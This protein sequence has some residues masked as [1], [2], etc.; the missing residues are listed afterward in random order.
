METRHLTLARGDQRVTHIAVRKGWVVSALCSLSDES[1]W[2]VGAT[3]VKDCGSQ[4]FIKLA[5]S[6]DPSVPVSTHVSGV[7]ISPDGVVGIA[8]SNDGIHQYLLN[9]PIEQFASGRKLTLEPVRHTGNEILRTFAWI[10]DSFHRHSMAVLSKQEN[11]R[12]RIS[13][14]GHTTN[15][16]ATKR[17]VLC[18]TPADQI[19]F[20]DA[21]PYGHVTFITPGDTLDNCN[22]TILST[23]GSEA[24]FN[25]KMVR[26][27]NKE[28]TACS[29]A[30]GNTHVV[31]GF[32]STVAAA[33]DPI[34]CVEVYS[35]ARGNKLVASRAIPGAEPTAL[36]TYSTRV[37]VGASQPQLFRWAVDQE[38]ALSTSKST[39]Y[40]FSTKSNE[41][42][43]ICKG[44]EE[45]PWWAVN[46]IAMSDT[47][48]AYARKV[49]NVENGEMYSVVE[50]ASA[51][52]I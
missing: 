16:L 18:E 27:N 12:E 8:L 21:S 11:G 26:I 29:L 43:A 20:F 6:L 22:L 13:V 39:L 47:A 33:S 5:K 48:W 40:A 3:Y 34:G 2:V 51:V 44:G 46:T 10:N 31:V 7:S 36:S 15:V 30:V 24:L 32:A 23:N 37:M 9:D 41:N 14:Y 38:A 42:F 49:K 1:T 28:R 35:L 19:Q 4:A 50:H 17:D 25:K 45:H 52:A